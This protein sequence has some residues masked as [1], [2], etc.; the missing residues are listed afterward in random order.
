MRTSRDEHVLFKNKTC[1]L[2]VDDDM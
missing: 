2:D 1:G